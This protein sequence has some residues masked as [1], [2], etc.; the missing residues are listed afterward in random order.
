MPWDVFLSHATEDKA[1]VADPLRRALTE[2]GISVW[3]DGSEIRLGDSMRRSME[4]GLSMS[5]W[6]VVVVSPSFLGKYWPQAELDALFAKE[7]VDRKVI[8]P[9]YYK[10]TPEEVREKHLILA[11]KKAILWSDGLEQ[12]VAA[13]AAEVGSTPGPISPSMKPPDGPALSTSDVVLV[14]APS[15][16]SFFVE[17]TRMQISE[18][19]EVVL[20]PGESQQAPLA[21]ALREKGNKPVAIAFGLRMFLGTV[22]SVKEEFSGGRRFIVVS[23]LEDEHSYGDSFIR[24]MAFNSLSA[25]EVAEMRARR[26]LLDEKLPGRIPYDPFLEVLVSGMGIPL[27]VPSSPFPA[28]FRDF[29]GKEEAF[30]VAA[31]LVGVLW[32]HLSGVVD[33]IT[34]LDLMMQAREEMAVHFEGQRPKRFTNAEP[35]RVQID[36]VC[37]LTLSSQETK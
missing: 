15:G 32:L 19:A 37:P 9:V 36:G 4:K 3:I 24:D 34:A 2:A 7:G 17:C 22:K 16:Q 33:Q 11:S 13:I 6:G 25:D 8:L 31:R 23:L 28:L 18:A 35:Y 1:A 10:V 21:A 29:K 27:P 26:I 20:S 5:R 12:V 30:L 14:L